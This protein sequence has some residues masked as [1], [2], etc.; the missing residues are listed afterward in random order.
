MVK[1]PPANV[2]EVRDTGV[3]PAQESISNTEMDP[4]SP[5]PCSHVMVN[6]MRGM[7]PGYLVQRYSECVQEHVS[8]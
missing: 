8:R 7:V 5:K 4:F 6:F 2:G 1:N 3:T